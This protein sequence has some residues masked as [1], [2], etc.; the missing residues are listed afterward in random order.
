MFFIRLFVS[1]G[2]SDASDTEQRLKLLENQLRRKR[3]E[4]QKLRK[5]KEKEK[6]R[7]KEQELRRE[8]QV[9]SF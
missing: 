4:L 5:Q 6:L 8:L 7:Q 3:S 1:E 2:T 9:K